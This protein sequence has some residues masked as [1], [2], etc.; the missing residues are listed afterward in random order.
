MEHDLRMA[1]LHVE[2]ALR[3]VESH[4]GP[5]AIGLSPVVASMLHKYVHE[6]HLL[7]PNPSGPCGS[8][9]MMPEAI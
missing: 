2:G 6:K 8:K 3:I 4:G 9:F 7:E 1:S 5:Q